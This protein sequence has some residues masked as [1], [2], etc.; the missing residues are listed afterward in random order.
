MKH[1]SPLAA[2]LALFP[3]S[4]MRLDALAQC[5]AADA[6]LSATRRRDMLS[7]IARVAQALG[8][9]PSDIPCQAKWLQRRLSKIAPAQLGITHKTWTNNLSN[10]RSAMAHVGIVERRKRVMDD[11]TPDWRALWQQVR[12]AKDPTVETAT[13]RFVFFLSALHIPPEK[14]T[15]ADADAFRDALI[16]AEISKDPETAWRMAINGWNLAATRFPAWPRTRLTLPNR[17]KTII[18]PEDAYPTNLIEDVDV[19]IARL[20]APDLLAEADGARPRSKATCAHYRR[21]ILRFAADLVN[22][23]MPADEITGLNVLIEP[24]IAERGLRQML[25][26][27][28]NSTNRSIADMAALLRNLA[29]LL[30]APASQRKALQVLA[31]KLALPP[32]K[33]MTEKN[34]TR[35]RVLQEPSQQRRLLGL[36]DAIFA[37]P[38]RDSRRHS[39]LLAREDALAIALLLVCPL[40]IK[41]L[42]AIDLTRHIQRPGD[43]RVFL[44]I[45]DGETKTGQPIEFELPLDVVALL[46]AHAKIR[47]PHLCPPGTRF[48]FPKRCGSSS[49]DGT[50]L[51]SRLSKRLRKELGIDMNAHLFRHFAVMM[52]LDANPGGYEVARRLLGHKQLSHTINLYSG[53]E[54]KTASR[55]FADLV[56]RLRVGA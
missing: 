33:G 26:R 34:R 45:E 7:G 18:L 30:D 11:L 50:A 20:A 40:R 5:I 6:D 35:L 53:L 4:P 28:G 42:A 46:D 2:D 55:A 22:A 39:D 9:P 29:R 12:A 47:V 14:V 16:R 3:P 13:R 56:N 36:P 31:K 10:L 51:S 19:L 38:L 49:I 17:T 8:L 23:G 25:A 37:R 54:A 52:W 21:Q 27:F 1:T 24:A 15:Q 41:N 44:V 48:L 43:G 32:Q